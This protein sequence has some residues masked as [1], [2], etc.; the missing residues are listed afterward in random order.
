MKW[1]SILK[2]KE[3]RTKITITLFVP[4]EKKDGG[5]YVTVSGHIKRVDE[6]E[7]LLILEEGDKIPMEDIYEISRV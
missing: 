7:H 2:K 1:K 5:A 3:I 6:A 4:D